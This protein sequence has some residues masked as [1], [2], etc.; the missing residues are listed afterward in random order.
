ML[1]GHRAGVAF[2]SLAVHNGCV[3]GLNLN[4]AQSWDGVLAAA[5]PGYRALPVV[6]ATGAA[7]AL[8]PHTDQTSWCRKPG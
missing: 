6:A 4:M 3:F 8:L 1:Y 5:F 7:E 2:R